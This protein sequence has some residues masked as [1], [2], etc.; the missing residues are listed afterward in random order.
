[1][2]VKK[3]RNRKNHPAQEKV[4]AVLSVWT[5]SS[6]QSEVCKSLGI[7]SV[8]LNKWQDLAMEAMLKA[9]EPASKKHQVAVLTPCLENLLNRQIQ[10]K[11]SKVSPQQPKE[12][13]S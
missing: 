13:Q 8:T 10:K 3:K 4:Q 12:N 5:E 1:M 2:T 7:S 9:L 6:S 11:L